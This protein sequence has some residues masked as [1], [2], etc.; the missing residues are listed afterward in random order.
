MVW[1]PED[2]TVLPLGITPSPANP[3]SL[4]RELLPL[5]WSLILT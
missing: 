2:E 3:A 4:L 5:T 1:T